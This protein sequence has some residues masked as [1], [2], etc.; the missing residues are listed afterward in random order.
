MVP[1]T[2]DSPDRTPA[3]RL[4]AGLDRIEAANEEYITTL[5]LAEATVATMPSGDVRRLLVMARAV[6]GLAGDWRDEA[7]RLDARASRPGTPAS[8]LMARAQAHEDLAADLREAVSRALLGEEADH[9]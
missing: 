9:G 5:A 1:V 2:A 4:A 6:L 3:G 7:I 8:V